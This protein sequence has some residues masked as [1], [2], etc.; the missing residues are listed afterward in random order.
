MCYEVTIKKCF[1]C[2]M[3][4]KGPPVTTKEFCKHC[5]E[6]MKFISENITSRCSADYHFIFRG[7]ELCHCDK[8][9]YEYERTFYYYQ[10]FKH[11]CRSKMFEYLLW[12]FRG[13][14]CRCTTLFVK[15]RFYFCDRTGTCRDNYKTLI[16]PYLSDN[17]R[18]KRKTAQQLNDELGSKEHFQLGGVWESTSI[19]KT[20]VYHRAY[21]SPLHKCAF[22]LNVW[23]TSVI[24]EDRSKP[25]NIVILIK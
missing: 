16:R 13:Y 19:T 2:A 8:C 5:F 18:Y 24:D 22:N 7:L 20:Y 10:H 17:I 12:I 9:K 3:I 15:R 4:L 25:D 23:Q 21:S 11:R 6:A 14:G 1:G